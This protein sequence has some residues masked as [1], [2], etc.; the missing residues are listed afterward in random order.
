[1]TTG[2]SFDSATPG[3]AQAAPRPPLAFRTAAEQQGSALWIKNN[4]STVKKWI[5]RGMSVT[6]IIELILRILGI[7]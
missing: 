6:T 4:W 1:L 3:H 7:G 2:S 5:E